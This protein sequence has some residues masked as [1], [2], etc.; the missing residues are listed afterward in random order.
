[1]KRKPTS[2]KIGNLIIAEVSKP[3][4]TEANQRECYIFSTEPLTA[5]TGPVV[6][7]IR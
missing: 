5:A 7:V 2:G 6:Y 4:K 3:L 1:M